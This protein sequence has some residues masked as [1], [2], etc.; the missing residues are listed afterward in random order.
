MERDYTQTTREGTHGHATTVTS[1]PPPDDRTSEPSIGVLFGELSEDLGTLVRKEIELARVETTEKVSKAV[2]SA[3]T[4]V[5]GGLVAYAGVIVILIAVA[6]LL[7]EFMPYWLST[8][9]VGLVV[10][11]IGAVMVISGKNTLTNMSVVPEKT[12]DTLKEDARWAKEQ[13]S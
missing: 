9:V 6:I 2:R 7:G 3:V 13:V 1:A 12:V 5:A 11:I 4:L 10:A 8:L